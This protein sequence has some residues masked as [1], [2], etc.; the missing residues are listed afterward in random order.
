MP[1]A[2]PSPASAGG[3]VTDVPY[4]RTFSNDPSPAHL[5]LAVALGGFTPPPER[6]FDYLELGCGHGDTLATLA[7]AY[8]DA[9]FVGVDLNPEHIAFAR[10]TAERGGLD[11]LRFLEADFETLL[12]DATLPG[13]DY[14][15]MYGVI[16]WISPEKRRAALRLASAKL[17]KGGALFVSYNALPGW[18]AV[19][20][21]RR[22]LLDSAAG[23]AGNSRDRAKH[24]LG[25]A[26]LL[27][28][29]GAEYFVQNPAAASMLDTVM[30]AG[31]P[32][33]VHEY[34]HEDWHP[35]YFEDVAREMAE[36][37]LWFAAQVPLF[38]NYRDLAIPAS[39][40]SLF[41]GVTD[42]VAFE[43]LK[44]YALNQFFRRD[45]Y[46]KGAGGRSDE[47]T[48]RFLDETTFGTMVSAPHVKRQ[49]AL[50]S[51][52]LRYSGPLFDALLAALATGPHSA[53]E[54]VAMP[55]LRDHPKAMLRE[56]VLQLAIGDQITPMV[57]AAP[58]VAPSSR[59]PSL[60]S[61]H[62]RAVLG[63]P[64]TDDR[65]LVLASPATGRGIVLT[66][67]DAM[68]LRAVTE[69][70]PD[71]RPRWLRTFMATAKVKLSVGD[72]VVAQG[73][74]ELDLLENEIE[75]FAQQRVP[76]L[77]ELG[78]LEYLGAP[79]VARRS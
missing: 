16:S 45:V 33:A 31:L 61:R 15:A 68:C 13:C 67:L 4:L 24:A 23:A 6:D 79:D 72:G 5:R 20:P 35:H 28:Q 47:T 17:E 66:H 7:A 30:H 50:P 63:E 71:D 9:R 22:L 43:C 53:S 42:R 77:V 10:A 55:A 59:R 2:S 3:Y 74:D 32:Y 60:P 37:D 58:R 38:F 70:D 73:I 29:A 41:E 51:C 54:L 52:T 48:Q 14:V 64:M 26:H 69:A 27:R 34:F 36:N 25:V 12:E 49:V 39:M 40:R 21:L 57:R 75:V 65:P 19:A 56:A 8:P 1:D 18:A 78:V 76:K 11:N 46:L 62:N 44:D